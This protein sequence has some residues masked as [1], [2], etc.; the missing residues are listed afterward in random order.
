MNKRSSSASNPRLVESVCTQL[1]LGSDV[2]GTGK[3]VVLTVIAIFAE[4]LGVPPGLLIRRMIKRPN[5]LSL[6]PMM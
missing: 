1:L 5:A 2:H 6:A 4:M 3:E